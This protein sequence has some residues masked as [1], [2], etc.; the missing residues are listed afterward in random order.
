MATIVNYQV[1]GSTGD[2]HSGSITADSGRAVADP[3]ARMVAGTGGLASG[4]DLTN[5]WL[6]P[7]SHG[8]DATAA[9]WFDGVLVPKDATIDSATF[10]L[11][12]EG[13]NAGASVVKYWVSAQASDDAPALAY[14]ANA[15]GSLAASGAASPPGNRPRTTAVSD[16][17][18]QTNCVAAT[19]YSCTITSVIQEI[20]S[21]AGW[22][23]GNA[24]LILVDTHA[25]TTVNEW[26][27][28]YSYDGNASYA[29]KLS[30]TY[31]SGV[32]TLE[33]SITAETTTID[34]D[35]AGTQ[36]QRLDVLLTAQPTADAVTLSEAV[37]RALGLW[38]APADTVTLS[39]TVPTPTIVLGGQFGYPISDV[40][41]GGWTPV[42]GSD[43]YAM[44]DEP[45]TPVDTDDYIASGT[46][47][48]NDTVV[49]GLTPT[50]SQP[51][52]GQVTL[53]VR[54]RWAS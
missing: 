47:P 44:L 28:Y 42:T 21:R 3:G 5:V 13:Y 31:S 22:A 45:D 19:E 53:R 49:L 50:L 7:G 4:D 6:Q 41:A 2:G 33:P 30:I 8:T 11:R 52:T 36:A 38:T 20:V 10:T 18:T 16:P 37:A 43:L 23:S 32:T 46:T 24:I 40:T 14:Y 29:P 15:G 34:D 25:D 51:E 27:N 1:A 12:A 17:W 39:E 48:T 54:A 35:S 26:Q 9:A